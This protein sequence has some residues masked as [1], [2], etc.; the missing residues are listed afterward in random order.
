M[1]VQ[2]RRV[3]EVNGLA[4]GGKL[5]LLGAW[6]GLVAVCCLAT[7][8]GAAAVT[9]ISGGYS[10]DGSL[11]L[12]TVVS[13]KDNTTD[14]V[15]P[16]KNSNVDGLLGVVIDN[17]GSLLSVTNTQ[18]SQ[19]QVATSGTADVLVSD[20]NGTVVRGD[21]I[22]ASPIAGVGMKA[23]DNVRIVGIAQGDLS[24]TGKKTDYKDDKGQSHSTTIG[25]VPLLIGVAYYFKEPDKTLVPQALQNIANALA[26]K[27]V[28]TLPILISGGIF[29][30]MMVAVASI[31]YSMIRSSI[32]SVGR[33]PMSQ[34]AVYRNLIQ[35]T[36]LVL[37]ILGIGFTAMYLVLTRL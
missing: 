3:T 5:R 4:V 31:I 35:M 2:S 25:S 27:T 9:T 1:R 20:I 6:A 19:V 7:V 36:A 29:V 32:I 28:S 11:A 15:V 37:V 13:L 18:K 16:A 12:G 26:G 24:K 8:F 34:S 33:N 10:A 22:T 23:S 21:H 14:F 30:V 17:Q